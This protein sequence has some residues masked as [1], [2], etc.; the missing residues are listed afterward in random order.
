M[1]SSRLLSSIAKSLTHRHRLNLEQRF[2][3]NCITSRK[4][5]ANRLFHTTFKNYNDPKSESEQKNEEPIQKSVKAL[6]TPFDHM[7]KKEKDTFLEVVRKYEQR[8]GPKTDVVK[9]VTIALKYMDEF[10][11]N[12]DLSV[13]KAL[14][15]VFPK[16]PYVPETSLQVILNFEK[17]QKL[18]FLICLQQ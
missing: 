10:G 17:F 2:L 13:Y 5:S 7:K 18:T 15:N 8:L 3:A 4:T 12:K 14:L 9:F 1:N 6:M 11:V 16:G